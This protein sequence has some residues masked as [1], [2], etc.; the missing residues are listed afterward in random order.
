[1]VSTGSRNILEIL[2]LPAIALAGGHIVAACGS[3]DATTEVD[4]GAI[5]EPTTSTTLEASATT[6]DVPSTSQEAT[7]SQTERLAHNSPM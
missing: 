2:R 7:T 6:E 4:A 3:V 1:M 5:V